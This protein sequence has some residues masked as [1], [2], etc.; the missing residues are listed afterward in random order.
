[1][2]HQEARAKLKKQS[3]TQ[4]EIETRNHER[5]FA[6]E[7]TKANSRELAEGGATASHLLPLVGKLA[8]RARLACCLSVATDIVAVSLAV[9]TIAIRAL[10]AL[11]VLQTER[12]QLVRFATPVSVATL[13]ESLI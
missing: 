6:E 12:D 1:M 4:R 13:I 5:Q 11:H 2:L 10:D 8:S 9:H 3:K 7:D